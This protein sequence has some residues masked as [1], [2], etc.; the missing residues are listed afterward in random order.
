MNSLVSTTT[1]YTS[2]VPTV[3][4]AAIPY[5]NIVSASERASAKRGIR[6][7][8]SKCGEYA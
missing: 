6:P 5:I 3:T 7:L 1:V 2:T 8:N 4:I